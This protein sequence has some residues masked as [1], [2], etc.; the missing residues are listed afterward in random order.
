MPR[1][2]HLV[3]R[4]AHALL[5]MYGSA[6]NAENVEG[7]R[8]MMKTMIESM[9]PPPADGV[10]VEE[11]RIPGPAGAPDVRVLIYTPP[12]IA[13][14]LPVHLDIHG[15]GYIAGSAD[16]DNVLCRQLCTAVSCAVVSV[17]YRLA[18]EVQYPGALEDCYAALQWLH[19]QGAALGFD[20]TRMTIGGESAGG[21]HGAAMAIRIRDRGGPKVLLQ[22]LGQPML[23]DRTGSTS[24]PHP[25][26]GEFVWTPHLNRIGWTSLLGVEAGSAAVPAGAVAARVEDLSGL[27][28]AFVVVG[29]LDL[30]VEEAIEYARRLMR[31]GVPTELHVLPGAFHGSASIVPDA[32]VSVA[33]FRLQYEA[34]KRAFAAAP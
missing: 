16:I 13:G 21:G 6:L 14:P 32:L 3:M 18:P 9:P 27:A 8:A 17:D 7:L 25:Y 1:S 34:L 29:A 33:Y 22:L 30:F 11:R 23:D 20:T 2:R 15:G 12:G 24:E 28:P 10:R 31:A 4:E 19:R 5:D 26:T